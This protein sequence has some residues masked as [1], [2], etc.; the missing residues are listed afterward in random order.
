MIEKT[1]DVGLRIADQ[2]FVLNMQH[3]SGQHGIPMV[4]E[5]QVAAVVTPEVGQVVAES[6]PLREVLFEIAETTVH[7][8]PASVDDGRPR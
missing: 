5:R 6:L 1:A 4:H 8:M 2:V 7:G 3:L